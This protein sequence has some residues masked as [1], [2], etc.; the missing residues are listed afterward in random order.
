MWQASP[1]QLLSIAGPTGSGKTAT[2]VTL[3]RH[4]LQAGRGVSVISLDSRQ[5]YQEFPLLSVADLD[6]WQPLIDTHQSTFHLYNLAALHLHEDWSF[7]VLLN[8]AREQVQVAHSRGDQIILVGGT[9]VCHQRLLQTTGDF[10]TIPPDDNVRF[11]AENMTV[12]ELQNWLE[13]LDPDTYTAM[14]T[15]DRANPRRLVRKIEIALAH[16]LHLPEHD[17]STLQSLTQY[18]YIPTLARDQLQ[19]NVTARVQNR[20]T[21]PA[22]HQE[23]QRVLQD[24]PD[25]L[26]QPKLLSRTPLGFTQLALLETNRLDANH[27]LQNWLHDEWHYAKKQLTWCQRL[28]SDHHTHLIDQRELIPD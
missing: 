20:F 17:F 3:A 24:W 14:N 26:T 2:A 28:I 5:V 16:R 4:W 21:D 1:H 25:I 7:G 13:K 15:S 12:D 19:A 10:T 8:A 22:V 9:I 11:A 23:V 18:W 27:A 6:T